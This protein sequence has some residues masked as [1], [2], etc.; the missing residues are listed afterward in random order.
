MA[1]I[2]VLSVNDKIAKTGRPYKAL[3][4]ESEGTPYKVNVFSSAPDFANINIGSVLN[5]SL[6]KD[7]NFWNISFPETEKPRYGASGGFK[8]ALIEKAMDTKRQDIS[9]FQDNK[10][11]SIKMASTLRMATD[12]AIAL[13]PDQREGTM[14]ETI[15][16][17]REWFWL[18]W[19]KTTS[20][21][22][23]PF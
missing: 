7:G 10:E 13:T 2:K 6:V 1:E 11:L 22:M 23:P 8:T 21:E 15:R 17:W 19:E 5:G 18:E 9:K 14:Q 3:E 4:V 16:F 12:V 20:E